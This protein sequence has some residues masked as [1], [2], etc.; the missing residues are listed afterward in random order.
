M[1]DDEIDYEYG[2]QDPEDIDEVDK[3]EP[4]SP[5][6]MMYK[7]T[8]CTFA[9]KTHRE[10]AKHSKASR[11]RTF[12]CKECPRVFI[13]YKALSRHIGDK[14]KGRERVCSQ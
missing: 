13:A 14:H 3:S 10:L 12:A 2:P 5:S 7:C 8:V 4:Q 6:E 9:A 11:H 1:A